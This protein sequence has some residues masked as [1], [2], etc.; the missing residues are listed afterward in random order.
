MPD[1][2]GAAVHISVIIPTFGRASTLP[3]CLECLAGVLPPK[4][5]WEVLVPDTG[6]EKDQAYV[7]GVLE[8]FRGRLPGLRHLFLAQEG[9][10]HGRHEG[11][12][13]AR[14]EI[15]SFLD[16]DS[17]VEPT[18]LQGVEESFADPT[19]AMAG[20]P[21]R[22]AFE[23]PE[24]PWVSL[25]WQRH[26]WGR[27][28]VDLSL[29]DFGD[30]VRDIEPVWLWGCNFSIRKEAF[31]RVGGSHPDALPP[32]LQRYQ[33][34]GETA[35]SVRLAAA[36]LRA[37][38]NGR[39]AIGHCV[40]ASRMTPEYFRRRAFYQGVCD[41][42][43]AIRRAHGLGPAD[44]VPPETKQG[45]GIGVWAWRAKEAMRFAACRAAHL[46][47]SRETPHCAFMRVRRE[48]ERGYS[49]GYSYHQKE[50]AGDAAL[51]KWVLKKTYMDGGGT[52]R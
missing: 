13:E 36:G 52:P 43:T 4:C 47:T 23:A 16:H 37:V 24:V 25:F 8:N 46:L 29:L 27:F 39:M 44:G 1:G 32:A 48:T 6:A 42:F 5:N 7:E 14:G 31:L 40:P 10:M 18:W 26:E 19:V 15:L 34:D 50:V 3:R 22:P 30:Q 41:S 33:G 20:G 9:L 49:D 17:Y 2:T 51:L 45:A 38:Y 28:M 12:R 11:L 21:N 35:L